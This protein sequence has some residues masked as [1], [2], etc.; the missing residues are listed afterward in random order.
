MNRSSTTQ[1]EIL[2]EYTKDFKN[3]IQLSLGTISSVDPSTE[4]SLEERFQHQVLRPILKFQHEKLVGY[5]LY[6]SNLKK[7]TMPA[8]SSQELRPWIKMRLAK[9]I[10][11]RYAMIGMIIGLFTNDVLVIYQEATA[12]LSKR[13][14]HLLVERIYDALREQTS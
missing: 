7:W 2:D 1:K 13:I 3:T 14:I 8:R 11:L 4:Q 6:Y 12:N 5:F 9:D 10:Q